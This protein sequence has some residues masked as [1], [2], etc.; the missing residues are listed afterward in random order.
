MS[1]LKE[2]VREKIKV[3]YDSIRECYENS[4]NILR[5]DHISIKIMV[6]QCKFYVGIFRQ[7]KPMT[8]K[9][10][11]KA[12][13]LLL[14]NIDRMSKGGCVVF[15]YACENEDLVIAKNEGGYLLLCKKAKENVDEMEGLLELLKKLNYWN[16]V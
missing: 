7:N 2:I 6:Q 13:E 4:L 15:D 5:K 10:Y 9:A 1:S 8:M 11:H 12:K 14:E 16:S 3:D